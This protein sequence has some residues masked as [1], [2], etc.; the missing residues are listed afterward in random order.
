MIGELHIHKDVIR[1][2]IAEDGLLTIS[3]EAAVEIAA[4]LDT[5]AQSNK[6]TNV[7]QQGAMNY[8]AVL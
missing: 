3:H 1:A 2:K 7:E 6:L 8:A 5:A 4:I